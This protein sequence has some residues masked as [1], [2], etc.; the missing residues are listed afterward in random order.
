MG[1]ARP[2]RERALRRAERLGSL[3][4]TTRPG[5]AVDLEVS[6]NRRR[7]WSR[8]QPTAISIRTDLLAHTGGRS[9]FQGLE[10]RRGVAQQALLTSLF[11]AQCRPTPSSGET[12]EFTLPMRDSTDLAKPPWRGLIAASTFDKTG[13]RP[14][15]RFPTDGAVEQIRYAFDRLESEGRVELRGRDRRHRFE[16][17]RLLNEGTVNTTQVTKPGYRPP[18]QVE[19]T[20]AVPA[21]FWLNGWVHALESNEII[22]YFML[23]RSWQATPVEQRD[24]GI[25]MSRISFSLAFGRG[26]GGEAYRMLSRYGLVG[27]DRDPRRR[28]DGTVRHHNSD[29]ILTTTRTDPHRFHVHDAEALQVSAVSRVEAALRAQADGMGMEDAQMMAVYDYDYDEMCRSLGVA[30]DQPIPHPPPS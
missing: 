30:M 14:T 26:R 8:H 5:G 24:A 17:I 9:L 21:E 7:L 3:L 29:D 12:P 1:E 13:R 11:L 15:A 20:I 10:S 16:R 28:D 18:R 23:L 6:E 19:D 22:A 4:D 25:L 27:I 2:W